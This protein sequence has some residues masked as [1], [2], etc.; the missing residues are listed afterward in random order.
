MANDKR[1][2][3]DY[4]MLVAGPVPVTDW[5]RNPFDVLMAFDADATL[6]A[7]RL[8]GSIADS[9]PARSACAPAIP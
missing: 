5:A 1:A 7:E 2:P 9:E 4:F 8:P 6:A 3:Y